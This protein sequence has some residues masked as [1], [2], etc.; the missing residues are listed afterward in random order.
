MHTAQNA[1]RDLKAFT[2]FSPLI[3][4]SA[5]ASTTPI[6]VNN[7]RDYTVR[8]IH[9]L[10]YVATDANAGVALNV[11]TRAS[12]AYFGTLTSE[13]SKA[14]DSI[15]AMTLTATTTLVKGTPLVI[16]CAGT[17]TGVGQ[18]MIAVELVPVDTK[19]AAGRNLLPL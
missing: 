12:A 1:S 6:F 3:T 4:L 10:Y 11:G 17:K 15:T 9:V 19:D 2:V 16:N 14:V 13:V 18:V 8:S 5:A 7:N